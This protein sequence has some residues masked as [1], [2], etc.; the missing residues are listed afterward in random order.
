MG[1]ATATDGNATVDRRL[2]GYAAID[3]MLGAV[4]RELKV[5]AWTLLLQ[6]AAVSALIPGDAPI[7]VPRRA[8]EGKID[9]TGDLGLRNAV[10]PLG[11]G[12]R[13]GGHAR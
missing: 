3:E 2:S 7:Q 11:E 12:P 6:N 1:A 5:A 10:V 4:Q 8:E 9:Y 13:H